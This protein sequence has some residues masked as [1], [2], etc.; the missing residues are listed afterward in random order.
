MPRKKRYNGRI[1]RIMRKNPEVGK[2]AM[3]VPVLICIL[4]NVVILFCST[5]IFLEYV[6]YCLCSYTNLAFALAKILELFARS[7]VE[8]AKRFT[9]SRNGRTL[10]VHHLKEIVDSDSRLD[11]LK[12]AVQSAF[13]TAEAKENHKRAS[14][15]RHRRRWQDTPAKTKSKREEAPKLPPEVAEDPTPPTEPTDPTDTTHP[16]DTTPPTD[17]ADTTPP[18]DAADTT[19]PALHKHK[20]LTSPKKRAI[21]APLY[22]DDSSDSEPRLYICL[23]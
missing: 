14:W 22:E 17:S 6:F 9:Q 19:P 1:K 5:S 15:P 7:L 21:S 4:F 13:S 20:A 11:F 3:A 8:R 10:Q 12:E 18:T 23:D 16:A 2:L